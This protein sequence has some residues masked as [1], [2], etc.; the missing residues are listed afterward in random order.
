MGLNKC[1]E[2]VRE[3]SEDNKEEVKKDVVNKSSKHI[4]IDSHYIKLE[5][6]IETED[7]PVSVIENDK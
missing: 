4:S 6:K 2:R 1:Q 7:S 5:K 3:E